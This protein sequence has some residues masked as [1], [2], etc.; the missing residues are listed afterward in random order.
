M[1]PLLA[2]SGVD[3]KQCSRSMTQRDV[4]PWRP[5][6]VRIHVLLFQQ[7]WSVEVECFVFRS[8]FGQKAAFCP[9]SLRTPDVGVSLRR[10]MQDVTSLHPQKVRTGTTGTLTGVVSGKVR[11][12][13]LI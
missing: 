11:V 3:I 4:Q 9:P 1:A 12:S 13:P 2:C 5:L 6:W 7:R 8:S 10:T